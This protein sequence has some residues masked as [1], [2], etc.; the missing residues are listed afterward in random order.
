VDRTE[1]AVTA[2]PGKAARPGQHL[3]L[4][5]SMNM[6]HD[7]AAP[8]DAEVKIVRLLPGLIDLVCARQC[9]LAPIGAYWRLLAPIG[10]TE[11][12]RGA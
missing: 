12:A 2:E 8:A 4:I 6:E 9:L 10:A 11:P 5:E 7:V 3:L 1:V